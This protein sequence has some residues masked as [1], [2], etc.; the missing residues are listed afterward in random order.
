MKYIVYLTINLKSKVNNLN[1]IYVGVHQTENPNIFDRYLGCGIYVGQP[2]TYQYGKTPLQKAVLKYGESAF[3]RCT[4]FTFDTAEEAYKKESEIVDLNFIKQEHVYNSCLGGSYYNNYKPLYQFDLQGNLIK[5]WEYSKEAYD[6]YD[7]SLEEFEYAIY[8]KHPLLNYIWS[9]QDSINPN[10]YTDIVW[11]SPKKCYLYSKEGKYLKEFRSIKDIA[12]E[13]NVSTSTI[14]KCIKN[15]RLLNNSYYICYFLTDL[16]IPK[17]RI[18]YKD[19]T[20]YVYNEN[21]ELLKICKGKELMSFID[22][23]S[24]NKVSEIF[25]KNE[26]WY[27]KYYISLYNIKYIPPRTRSTRIKVDVYDLNGNF[28]ETLDTVKQVKQK[29]H[30][31]DLKIKNIQ[32][33]DKYY[34]DWIFKYHP[35]IVNDIV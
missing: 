29:Y 4:L 5:K 7:T 31:S 24:W 19:E 20:F 18:Q 6:Y 3:L 1:R 15:Q 26:G 9:H 10:E 28:I 25:T 33:S 12:N 35:D 2:S 13:F 16:F 17:P 30:I 11:G 32:R 34:K 27:K 22:L 8:R 21:S 14:S 23:H